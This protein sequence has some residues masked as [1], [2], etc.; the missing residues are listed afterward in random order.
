MDLSARLR[1]PDLALEPDAGLGASVRRRAARIRRRRRAT[2]S[3]L[4]VAAV[5]GAAG[6]V[7]GLSGGSREVPLATDRS[8]GVTT[9]TS[10]VVLLERVNGADVVAFFQGD[11]PC[12]SAIRVRRSQTCAENVSPGSVTA[13]PALFDA[14]AKAL[15]VDDVQLFGGLVQESV[16]QVRLELAEGPPVEA[17]TR[18]GDGFLFPVFFAELPRGA[19][20]TAVVAV[21]GDGTEL[22]RR[23]P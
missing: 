14:G 18:R 8:Y 2:G 17:V 21:A 11:L 10:E 13:F 4:G 7:P 3:V 19:V 9:A 20:V 22:D 16:P 5:V 12:A 6:L 23:R 1:S 15:R